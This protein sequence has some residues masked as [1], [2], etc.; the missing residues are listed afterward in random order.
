MRQRRTLIWDSNSRSLDYA[1][2]ITYYGDVDEL[3]DADV[4]QFIKCAERQGCGQAVA[5]G[6]LHWRGEVPSVL[7]D[8][9]CSIGV[10]PLNLSRED[11]AGWAAKMV[12]VIRES[13]DRV[14]QSWVTR[15]DLRCRVLGLNQEERRSDDTQAT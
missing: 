15:Y 14:Y 8:F 12:A 10:D 3:T 13:T 11:V 4:L 9:V 7:I 1:E 6:N 2:R 5:Y